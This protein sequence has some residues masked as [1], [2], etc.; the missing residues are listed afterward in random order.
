MA[1]RFPGYA[2]PLHLRAGTSDVSAFVQVF[3]DGEYDFST[4]RPPTAVLDGGANVGC[5]AVYFAHRWP[6][7]RIVAVEPDRQNFDLLVRDFADRAAVRAASAT[8]DARDGMPS[9]WNR[10]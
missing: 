6:A 5:A 2:H 4:E 7:A 9:R 3:A 1:V 10:V 8:S